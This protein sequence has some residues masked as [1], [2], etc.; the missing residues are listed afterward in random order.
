[1][2]IVYVD[3]IENREQYLTSIYIILN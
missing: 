1:L 2:K 3:S